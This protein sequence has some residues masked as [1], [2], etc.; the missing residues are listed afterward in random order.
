MLILWLI[1][2]LSQA[3]ARLGVEIEVNEGG[4]HPPGVET[5][6]NERGGGDPPPSGEMSEEEGFPHLLVSKGARTG[7]VEGI[8]HLQI[9]P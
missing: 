2:N 3:T 7:E 9:E 6:E 1:L 4:R 5:D 8:P